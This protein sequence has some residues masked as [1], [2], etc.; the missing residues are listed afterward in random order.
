MKKKLLIAL[1][2]LLCMTMV[3]TAVFVT[4]SME[5]DQAAAD[6]KLNFEQLADEQAPTF[7]TTVPT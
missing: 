3:A 6:S 4:L 5:A 2:S 7:N 1:I